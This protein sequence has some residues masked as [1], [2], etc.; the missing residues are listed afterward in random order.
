M[1]V[2]NVKSKLSDDVGSR[3]YSRSPSSSA[4]CEIQE[5]WVQGQVLEQKLSLLSE[6]VLK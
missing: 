1:L 3:F 6:Q 4:L 2:R 5:A